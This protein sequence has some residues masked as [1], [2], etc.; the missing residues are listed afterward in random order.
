MLAA[1]FFF[2]IYTAHSQYHIN[3]SIPRLAGDTLV[4][5]HYFN[6]SIMLQDTFFLNSSGKA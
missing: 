2:A 1:A 5:G 4:F 6:E 3:L